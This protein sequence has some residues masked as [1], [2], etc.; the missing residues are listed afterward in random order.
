MD[1]LILAN[2]SSLDDICVGRLKLTNLTFICEAKSDLT[3][4]FMLNLW[5]TLNAKNF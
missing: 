1:K 4:E 2:K 3:K 5:M